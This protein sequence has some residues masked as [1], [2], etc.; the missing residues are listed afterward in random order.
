MGSAYLSLCSNNT[1]KN[2]AFPLSVSAS[3]FSVKG[4]TDNMSSLHW[5]ARRRQNVADKKRACKEWIELT[6]TEAE[7]AIE[8][9]A[10]QQC[11]D[12]ALPTKFLLNKSKAALSR[13]DGDGIAEGVDKYQE[14]K[15]EVDDT[16]AQDNK[17]KPRYTAR[18][19][20]RYSSMNYVQ[21][22]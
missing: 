21:Q 14:K 2:S 13:M 5:E 18:I 19:S 3:P 7:S 6:K 17:E 16:N 20:N 12:V 15:C 1:T 11:Q 8:E 22:Y 9:I 4:K 10:E